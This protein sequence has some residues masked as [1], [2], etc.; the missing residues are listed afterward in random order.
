VGFPKERNYSRGIANALHFS[1][2]KARTTQLAQKLG[3]K[4]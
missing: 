2:T 3:R 4:T 1:K